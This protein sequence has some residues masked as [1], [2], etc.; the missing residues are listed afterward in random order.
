MR[1]VAVITSLF[2][3]ILAFGQAKFSPQAR[4]LAKS[5]S[6]L[7]STQ[8]KLLEMKPELVTSYDLR[9]SNDHYYVGVMLLTDQQ[10]DEKSLQALD[11]IKGSQ[12]GNIFSVQV[13]VEKLGTLSTIPGVV[14]IEISE[15]GS[16]MLERARVSV[17][18]DSVNQGLGGLMKG[19]TG[20]NVIIAIIDWGSDYTHP[21]F[22]DSATGKLRISRA[23]DQNKLSGKKPVGYSYGAEY[24]GEQEL[25]AAGDDTVYVFGPGSHATH[26]GGISGGN[27]GGTIH[28]GMAPDA[29]LV[30]VALRRNAASFID[31]INYITDYAESVHKP[32]VVNMS[33][34]G[35]TGPHDGMELQSRAMDSLAGKGRIFVGSAGNNGQDKLHIR[36]GFTG[37]TDTLKTVIDFSGVDDY[38]GQYVSMWGS[39]NS[40]FSIQ[41]LIADN[42]NH[43]LAVSD[44]YSSSSDP[45]ERDTIIVNGNDTVIINVEGIGKSPLNDKPNIALDVRK[46]GTEKIILQVTSTDNSEVHLW[47]TMKLNRYITN[48]GVAFGNNFPGATGG[49]TDYSLGGPTGVTESVI[50]VAAYQSEFRLPNGILVYG[51]IAGFSSIGPTV[52][53]R[54]K[55]DIAGPGVDVTSAVNSFD[56]SPY[57]VVESVNKDGREYD[58]VKF[59]GTSMSGPAVTGVVALMLEANPNLTA[60]QVKNILKSSARLDNNTGMIGDTG[61]LRWG[62]GKVNALAAVLAAQTL[63]SVDAVAEQEEVLEVYP[64]PSQRAAVTVKATH[65]F[66]EI[67][68]FDLEGKEVKTYNFPPTQQHTVPSGDLAPG[69]YILQSIGKEAIGISKLIVQ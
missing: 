3:H 56:P 10:F 22:F 60:I 46:T 12:V 32:F 41:L 49:N 25:L 16:P 23:W 18:A 4:S 38:Y 57:T 24:V 54:R 13:P 17:R 66:Y 55:P 64:N 28:K 52:D 2:I 15:T 40:S 69:V 58:F 53:G 61:S 43:V 45:L 63:A 29:E 48:W 8:G 65:E 14:Y 44:M 51:Q 59:S 62:R 67:R 9:Y 47:N 39:A 7:V 19:Y 36:H 26:V 42:S 34:G 27:G 33:F 68:C 50:V 37:I 35:H 21:V 5:I 20:K 6:P 11:I 30:F 1:S 31:A